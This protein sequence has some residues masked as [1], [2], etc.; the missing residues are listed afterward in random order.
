[1]IT[2]TPAVVG[3]VLPAV[4]LS[5]SLLDAKG[6]FV[7]AQK[8]NGSGKARA[9][10]DFD[11]FVVCLALCGH[12]K[13]E[14]VEGMSLAARVSAIMENYLGQKDELTVVSAAVVKKVERFNASS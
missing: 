2:P 8:D 5:L 9:S 3:D 6:T 10:I 13:Y 14:R 7:T 4:H 12:V 11:E 1:M